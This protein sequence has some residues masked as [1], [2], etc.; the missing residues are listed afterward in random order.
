MISERLM[1]EPKTPKTFEEAVAELERIVHDLED[2][3]TGLEQALERYEQ[4]VSLLRRCYEQL[5]KVELRILE[6]TGKDETGN[7]ILKPFDHASSM[8]Q[9]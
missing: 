4:G 7:P 5:R 3:E 2:G 1:N 9:E 6:L 8:K